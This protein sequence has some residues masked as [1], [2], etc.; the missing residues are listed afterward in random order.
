MPQQQHTRDFSAISPSAKSLVLLKGLTSIPFARQTAE[1]VSSPDKYDPDIN[2]KDLAFWKRVVHFEIRYRSIDQLLSPLAISNILELSSGYSFRGLDTV[3]KTDTHYIDTD[4]PNIISQKQEFIHALDTDHTNTKGTLQM[5]PLNAL[6]EKAF[7]NIVNSFAKGPVVIVNEGLLMYL[8]NEEKNKL[9]K[10]IWDILKQR[11]GY[12]ITGDVYVKSTLERF[13]D[14]SDDGLKEL[15][16]EQRIED[17]MFESLDAA[18]AFFENAG[19]LIDK[20]AE[21]DFS[22][23]SSIKYLVNNATQAQLAEMQ[24]HPKIQ[25]S[26]RLKVNDTSGKEN[27]QKL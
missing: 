14:K 9:C 17:N 22:S 10:T 26:W 21:L 3:K 18:K 6:D 27:A 2:N 19:F 1:L 8:N 4:L 11:G 5:L 15:V 7:N 24:T 16:K 20:E 23:I 25:A 13:D 12:W